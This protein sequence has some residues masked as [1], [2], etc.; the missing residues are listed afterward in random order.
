MCCLLT[1]QT[2]WVTVLLANDVVSAT[3]INILPG[4]T[5]L[6]RQWPAS[7]PRRG[8]LEVDTAFL[9]QPAVFWSGHPAIY[10]LLPILPNGS[11][12]WACSLKTGQ[13][14]YLRSLLSF[15]SHRCRS[16]V[17]TNAC[18]VTRSLKLSNVEPGYYLDGWPPGKTEHCEAASVWTLICDWP[19]I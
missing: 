1:Q 10:L 4:H 16:A 3:Y 5:R 12:S 6:W 19:S 7:T 15:P 18:S 11:H 13:T 9:R 8:N 2:T 14:S 17:A